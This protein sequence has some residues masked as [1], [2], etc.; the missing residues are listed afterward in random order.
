MA[1]VAP[2]RL[3][4]WPRRLWLLAAPL[5]LGWGLFWVSIWQPA[6]YTP[7]RRAP[8]FVPHAHYL[9][10][11]AAASPTDL[12]VMWSPVLFALPTPMGFSRTP[13][14]SEGRERP[15]VQRPSLEPQLMPS[16]QM[17]SG[18]PVVPAPLRPTFKDGV[19]FRVDEETPVFT[20]PPLSAN[21]LAME[22][23]DGLAS[24]RTAAPALPTLPAEL[25]A[26]SWTVIAHLEIG[27][28]GG[29]QHVFLDPPS[30]SAAFNAQLVQSLYCWRL[31]PTATAT[32]GLVRFQHAAVSGA[33]RAAPEAATP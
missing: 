3:R 26:D 10:A 8:Q 21:A 15:R 17:A 22:L 18:K 24:R 19:N 5:A 16:P 33:M 14:T 32:A 20:A 13:S 23:L 6:A 7:P 27:R 30:A 25:T 4:R 9:P 1:A 12:R 31:L 2:G 28:D 29:V 11:R